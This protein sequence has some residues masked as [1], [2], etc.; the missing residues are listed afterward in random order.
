MSSVYV[1]RCEE[2]PKEFPNRCPVTGKTE[3]L[4]A[5]TVENWRFW[6]FL[7]EKQVLTLPMSESGKRIHEE[8]VGLL[9][10]IVY[11]PFRII[12]FIPIVGFVIGHMYGVY[13]GYWALLLLHAIKGP[14]GMVRFGKGGGHFGADKFSV[15]VPN[16]QW[17]EE[18]CFLNQSCNPRLESQLQNQ[19][20]DS[21]KRIA[22]GV[23]IGSVIML[24]LLAALIAAVAP[25][26]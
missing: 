15:V 5:E 18:F 4:T 7:I 20:S 19:P 16:K 22:I 26:S 2:Q 21:I 24:I 3:Q 9:R 17:A 1:V 25:K 11:M 14:A 8:S 13:F 6:V 10:R 12:L 23:G